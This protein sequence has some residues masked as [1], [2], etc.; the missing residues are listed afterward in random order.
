MYLSLSL[1]RTRHNIRRILRNERYL[2]LIGI[3]TDIC[4]YSV[5]SSESSRIN[6]PT[7][8]PMT[9]THEVGLYFPTCTKQVIKN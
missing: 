6:R 3:L 4:I 8:L 5:V 1:D 9:Q 7:F 2:T